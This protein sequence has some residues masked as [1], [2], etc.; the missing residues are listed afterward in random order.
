[1]HDIGEGLVVTFV[2]GKLPFP[3]LLMLHSDL[4]DAGD[5]HPSCMALKMNL[6]VLL[7]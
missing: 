6:L 1:M 3:L 5:E 2:L 4:N 7:F